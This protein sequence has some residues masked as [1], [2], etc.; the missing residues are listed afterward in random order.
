MNQDSNKTINPTH[1]VISRTTGLTEFEG[2]Y[3]Q[4]NAYMDKTVDTSLLGIDEPTHD[5]DGNY[6]AIKSN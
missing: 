1:K 3:S 2:S 4:C 5:E 6:N